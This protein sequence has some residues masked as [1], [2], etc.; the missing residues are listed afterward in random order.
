MS[1]SL[2]DLN[3]GRAFFFFFFF[4]YFCFLWPASELGPERQQQQQLF[5]IRAEHNL[6]VNLARRRHD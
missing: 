2:A 4:F 3:L 5:S 1:R 6:D